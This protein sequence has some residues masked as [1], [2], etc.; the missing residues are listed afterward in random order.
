MLS[1]GLLILRLRFLFVDGLRIDNDRGKVGE[2]ASVNHQF[3]AVSSLIPH[4]LLCLCLTEFSQ[5]QPSQL[6][7]AL[8]S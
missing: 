7:P 5:S 2:I 3:R 1:V 8:D 4:P 6:A